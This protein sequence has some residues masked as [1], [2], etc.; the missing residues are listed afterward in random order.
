MSSF[1]HKQ[2]DPHTSFLSLCL[3]VCVLFNWTD[4]ERI[5]TISERSFVSSHLGVPLYV[6][7]TALIASQQGAAMVHSSISPPS[8][9]IIWKKQ[10]KSSPKTLIKGIYT[11]STPKYDL[12]WYITRYYISHNDSCLLTKSI[13]LGLQFG[14]I[15]IID[16]STGYFHDESI[17]QWNIRKW[18]KTP[19]TVSW[20]PMSSDI[21]FCPTNSQNVSSLCVYWLIY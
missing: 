4:S 1:S 13:R 2:T 12:L 19:V 18:G 6:L 8:K 16:W 3:S 17:C 14:I 7:Y 20:S 9:L 11:V 10:S 21:L 5:N 15:F